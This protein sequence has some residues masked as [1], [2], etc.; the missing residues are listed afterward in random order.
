M[1]QRMTFYCES[2]AVHELVN[3]FGTH[4]QDLDLRSKLFL[5]SVLTAYQLGAYFA[6]QYKQKLDPKRLIDG[7]I[8]SI[9][10]DASKEL[11]GITDW[12]IEFVLNEEKW[13]TQHNI[14]G[15]IKGLTD[16]IACHTDY[17]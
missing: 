12:V 14:E 15:V 4:L 16:A 5:R 1:T 17:D 7:C 13:Q 3:T 11:P 2:D 9:D 6:E 10:P 8:E